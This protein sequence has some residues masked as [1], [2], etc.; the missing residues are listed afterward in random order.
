MQ[1]TLALDAMGGD[2]APRIVVE[3]AD[4]ALTASQQRGISVR[5]QFFGDE[6]R[7]ERLLEAH[8]N[9]RGYVDLI[10][11]DEHI[12]DFSNPHLV[13]RRLPRSSMRLAI[14]SVEQGEA[15]AVISA[16]N[17]GAYMA[18]SKMILKTLA[19]IDRPAIAG[20]TPTLKGLS[21]MLDLGANIDRSPSTYFQLA[22]MGHFLAQRVLKIEQPSIGLLNIGSEEAKGGTLIQEA[23]DFLRQEP[24]L[25]FHGFIEGNDIHAGKVDV[26]VTDG[27]SGNIS[28]KTG[29]GMVK[30]LAQ[31]AQEAI[32]STWRGKLAYLIAKP[33]LLSLKKRLDPR[34]YNGAT[35][36]GLKK[37]AIKSHGGTD[38]L[39]FSMAIQRAIDIV[40]D[41]HVHSVGQDIEDF[42]VNKNI[43]E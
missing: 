3:G 7:I 27:F 35:L 20:P 25:N 34:H 16:G 11:T 18:L 15:Q 17:T 37:I 6:S 28:L 30:F 22:V 29:E 40:A 23:A 10:H 14:E 31:V 2:E 32:Q 39:G 12:T 38:S 43:E 19:G 9:L 8:P 4:I 24:A 41:K 33:T 21:I 5:Y 36:L 1:V 13:L 42:L 26:I